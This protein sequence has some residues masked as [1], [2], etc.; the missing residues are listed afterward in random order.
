[1]ADSTAPSVPPRVIA[2]RGS[3]P[4][5]RIASSA[6]STTRGFS[7][8]NGRMLRYECRTS[9]STFARGS[10]LDLLGEA[11]Q[12]VEML[13][14]RV[15]VVASDEV[16]DR[17]FRVAGDRWGWT[18]P[19]RPP[20]SR[21]RRPRGTERTSSDASLTALT[22]LSFAAPGCTEEPWMV[23]RIDAAENVS[24]ELAEIRAVERVGDVGAERVE[25]E[26]LGAATDLL[27]DREGDAIVAV[28][29]PACARGRRPRP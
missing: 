4:A 17:L 27:V 16:D 25:V 22:S 11:A 24:L 9:T 8:M 21:A 15:V 28:A 23:T 2:S 7:S 10:S 14:E 13:L 1:M 29:H 20:S 18:Y 26:V 5:R 3:T 12:E 6:A 19:S